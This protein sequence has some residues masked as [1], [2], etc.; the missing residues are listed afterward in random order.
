[1]QAFAVHQDQYVGVAE[2]S[3]L[4][5]ASHVAF[6]EGK[7]CGQGAKYLFDALA[8]EAVQHLATYHFRLHG[9]ILQRVLGSGG[10]DNDF[11]HRR[12]L[13]G[14]FVAGGF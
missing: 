5:L 1:M 14:G 13:L 9:H 4:H 12:L 11:L 7:G 3:Q 10:C 6:V 2:A 8:S